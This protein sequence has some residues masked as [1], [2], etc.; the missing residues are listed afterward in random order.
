MTTSDTLR[1]WGEKERVTYFLDNADVIVPKRQEQLTFL[2]ELFGWPQHEPLVVLDLGAGFGTLTE[3]I[4]TRYPRSTVICVDGSAEMMKL[5][6]ERLAPYGARVRL[7]LADLAF[8]AWH[9]ALSGPFQAVVSALAIHHLPDERKQQLYHEVFDLL[10]PGGL[11]LNNDVVT[12]PPLMQARFETLWYQ[13]IQ[14]QEQRR[15]GV[16]RALAAIQAEMQELLRVADHQS[17]LTSLSVQLD[18][19]RAVGFQSVDCMWKYL[20]FAIFGGAKA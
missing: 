18:W 10:S 17:Q 11:F 13:E 20:D 8:P 16:Q 9:D 7:H 19:L 1:G 15:R 2:L 14:A 6:R 3:Q 12:S 4:L 5:A